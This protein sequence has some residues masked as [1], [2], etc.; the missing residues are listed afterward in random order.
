LQHIYRDQTFQA[1]INY[2]D[3]LREAQIMSMPVIHYDQSSRSG[4]QYMDLAQEVLQLA[5]LDG[6]G[7]ER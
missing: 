7:Y 5:H 3:K 4:R 6:A 1:L 2:D